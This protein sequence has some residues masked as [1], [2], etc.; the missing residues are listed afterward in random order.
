MMTSLY[1]R[2]ENIVGK[3][4]N[5]GYQHFL[6]FPQCF[7][8]PSFTGRLKSGLCGKELT[9]YKASDICERYSTHKTSYSLNISN[10]ITDFFGAQKYSLT[11]HVTSKL[12]IF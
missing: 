10:V 8:K 4:E 7:Q 3:R 1:D 5:A 12:K 9:P 11:F 6:L 2:V